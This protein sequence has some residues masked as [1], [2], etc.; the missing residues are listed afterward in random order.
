[1]KVLHYGSNG[2]IGNMLYDIMVQQGIAVIRGAS[3][4]DDEA[5]VMHELNKEKPTHV[6]CTLGRTHG[7]IDGVPIGTIDYLEYPDKLQENVRDNLYAP[8]QLALLCERMRIHFTYLGTGCIF[9]YDYDKGKT[10]FDENDKPNFFGSSYSTVKGFTDRL[11]HMFGKTTLNARIRMP[12]TKESNPRDFITKIVNYKK[13][14]SI[15]NSMTYLDEML[16]VLVNLM[17]AGHTGTV[18]LT[19]PGTICHNTILELYKELVN[20][21]HTWENMS[22][23]EQNAVLKSKRSNNAMVCSSCVEPHVSPI[24]DAIMTVLEYRKSQL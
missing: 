17:K 8:L 4:A 19:N 15:E 14:C 5:E 7:V 16:P 2:W 12:I 13:I 9:E 10:V 24:Q 21:T 23:E 18:H 22:I 6:L 20:P 3:R 1:M 11:M